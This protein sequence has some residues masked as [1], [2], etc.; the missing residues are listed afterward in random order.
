MNKPCRSASSGLLEQ[1]PLAKSAPPAHVRLEQVITARV[2]L[3]LSSCPPSC[4]DLRC[5]LNNA[6]FILVVIVI[7]V[8]IVSLWCFACRELD[9]KFATGPEHTVEAS[10]K[11]RTLDVFV[12]VAPARVPLGQ[13]AGVRAVFPGDGF[14]L[15]EDGQPAMP[16]YRVLRVY[17]LHELVQP[18]EALQEMRR[19]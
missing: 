9:R 19:R 7:V 8:I 1:L 17:M 11:G 3:Q 13:A 6:R 18:L 15:G 2:P 10:F 14:P 16:R 12:H 4:L 5:L